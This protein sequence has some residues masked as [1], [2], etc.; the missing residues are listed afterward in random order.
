ME[1][2]EQIRVYPENPSIK[3]IEQ[4]VAVLRSDGI[5]VVPTDTVYS[6]ACDL[7]SVKAMRRLARIKGLKPKEA[8]FSIV[9]DELSRLSQF[10]RPIP[11]SAFKTLKRCLPGPFTFILPASQSVPKLF[12]ANRKSIGIRIPD[13]NIPRALAAQLDGPLVVSSVHD[14]DEVIEYTTDP[15]LIAEKYAQQIELVL[16]AGYGDNSASTVVDMTEGHPEL[17][18]SGKGDTRLLD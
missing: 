5:V 6:F 9:F 8:K 4:A 13:H 11:S 2:A 15:E 14:P 12:Q 3:T 17:I 7:R 10:T 18:R 16:D 1:M